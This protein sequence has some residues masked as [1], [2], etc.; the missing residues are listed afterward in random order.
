M[1]LLVVDLAGGIG[2]HNVNRLI[3]ALV[4]VGLVGTAVAE[5]PRERRAPPDIPDAQ[6]LI[7]ACWAMSLAKRSS[8][9]NPKI[10]EGILDTVLC[11]E[12]VIADQYSYFGYSESILTRKELR[13]KL[14]ALRHSVGRLYWVIMNENPGCIPTC[15]TIKHTRH[16]SEVADVLERMIRTMIEQRKEYGF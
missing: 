14:E 3:L 15:G 4:L 5:H 12:D 8:V 9:N 16:L 13:E 11:L 6:A 10:R 7:D 2:E 1:I